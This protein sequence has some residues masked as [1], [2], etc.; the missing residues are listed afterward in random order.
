MVSRRMRSV[1][2]GPGLILAAIVSTMLLVAPVRADKP[3]SHNTCGLRN[4]CPA[5]SLSVQFLETDANSTPYP[6]RSDGQGTYVNGA[7]NVKAVFDSGGSFS[8]DTGTVLP[9]VRDMISQYNA[10]LSGYSAY[11]LLVQPG[12]HYTWGTSGVKV[13]APQELGTAGWPS[14]M[15]VPGD[16]HSD[17]TVESYVT[18]YHTGIEGTGHF[19]NR[20]VADDARRSHHLDARDVGDL[21]RRHR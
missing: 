9:A 5:I 2:V 18:L 12:A 1:S 20:P 6:L 4:A 8:F 21:Q 17:D 14:S 16:I 11:T 7:D 19:A 3:A 15:C 10:P 13:T